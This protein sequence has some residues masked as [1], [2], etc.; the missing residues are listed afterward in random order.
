MTKKSEPNDTETTTLPGN[1][2][3]TSRSG[4]ADDVLTWSG[5]EYGIQF[6]E[7]YHD[8]DYGTY[9]GRR[10]KRFEK[11]SILASQKRA[12]RACGIMEVGR[13]ASALPS[14]VNWAFDS[15]CTTPWASRQKISKRQSAI[16]PCRLKLR[17]NSARGGLLIRL[18]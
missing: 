14:A 10:S 13:S 5:A 1:P 6:D 9:W 12:W 11:N 2:T 4:I 16:S 17:G 15:G 7:G 8:I 3:I 18:G